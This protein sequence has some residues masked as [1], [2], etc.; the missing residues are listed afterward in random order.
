MNLDLL[1]LSS[2]I[3]LLVLAGSLLG[4]A[5]GWVMHR[6]LGP[7]L[8]AELNAKLDIEHSLRARETEQ[9]QAA[10]QKLASMEASLKESENQCLQAL[11]QRDEAEKHAT[12]TLNRLRG[13]Q[14][15]LDRA[16]RDSVPLKEHSTLKTELEQKLESK[17]R[18]IARLQQ[19]LAEQP[20]SPATAVA[21]AVK[22]PQLPPAPV[23]QPAVLHPLADAT[24]ADALDFPPAPLRE[25][26]DMVHQPAKAKAQPHRPDFPAIQQKLNELRAAST[27]GKSTDREKAAARAGFVERALAFANTAEDNVDDLTHIKH[28][29]VTLNRQ[30]LSIGICTFRQIAE[31][32]AAEHKIV[33]DLLSL[34]DRPQREKWQ[35]QAAA[36][37]E[38]KQ[39]SGPSSAA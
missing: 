36:L 34:K 11:Q 17:D 9:T 25:V 12:E 31:W 19:L 7:D 35:Q 23:I 22:V 27:K 32:T 8:K 21:P 1:F 38:K 26:R 13:L 37:L 15:Q 29:K 4:F 14:E 16:Q 2:Q 18:E 5:L 10:V 30:L 20:M 28:I 33:G 39:N 24:E 6:F 3:A